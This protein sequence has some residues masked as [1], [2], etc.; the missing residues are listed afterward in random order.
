MT[1][2]FIEIIIRHEQYGHLLSH[3]E[4]RLMYAMAIIRL[5]NG[6]VDRQQK[7]KFARSIQSIAR[8]LGLPS[9][10]VDLRHE[11]THERL[12][13]LTVLKEGALQAVDWLYH[14]YWI[15]NLK[16]ME[17]KLA[18]QENQEVK[19]KLN[20]YKECR[21]AYMKEKYAGSKKANPTVYVTCIE[22]LISILDEDVIAQDVI[23]LLLGVGGLVPTGKKK[24]AS[25]E[26][27]V[28]SKGLIELWTPL[29]QGLDDGFNTF[30]EQLITTMI[31]K[32]D[33][34]YG[35]DLDRP[36]CSVLMRFLD[37][38]VNQALLD[39]YSV[40]ATKEEEDATKAPS[41]LLTLSKSLVKV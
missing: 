26:N 2:V 30:G 28:V 9:W 19:A 29:I 8:M 34:N 14:N 25:A 24:R 6:L 15:H 10:F 5:V 33:I 40:F 4:L 7:G 23:P 39:P 41:Y 1:A 31:S 18:L 13:S 11:S 16:N 21:K 20:E 3:K 35:N 38:Q 27:M 36:I 22:S 32:L 12:P 37:F 17:Q